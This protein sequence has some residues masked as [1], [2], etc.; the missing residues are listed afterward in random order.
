MIEARTQLILDHLKA[1]LGAG[2]SPA[3][4]PARPEQFNPT[5]AGVPVLVQFLRL[6]PSRAG[7]LTANE[8]VLWAG[9]WAAHVLVARTTQALAPLDAVLSALEGA[10]LADLAPLEVLDVR[11]TG[12]H[13]NF[14]AYA[15][16]FKLTD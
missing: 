7:E 11:A 8:P 15:V 2:Y 1:V 10:Q 12:Q 14:W 16:R 4:F 13:Q 6:T 3:P 9:E 5:G